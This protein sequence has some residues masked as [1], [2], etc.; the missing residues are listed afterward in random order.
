VGHSTARR[1]VTADLGEHAPRLNPYTLRFAAAADEARYRAARDPS[2][3]RFARIVLGIVLLVTIAVAFLDVWIFSRAQRPYLYV[4]HGAELVGFAI[5]FGLTYIRGWKHRHMAAM[6][7]LAVFFSTLYAVFDVLLA[8]PRTYV[9]GVLVLIV[10]IYVLLPLDFVWGVATALFCSAV[11]LAI[12]GLWHPMSGMPLAILAFL[13]VSANV[14]GAVSLYHIERLRRLDFANLLRIAAER[15]R[16][17]TLLTK[18]LPQSIADRLQRGEHDIADRFDDATVM[19]ADLVGFT[20]AAAQ[21][22]PEE[23]VAFLE[24][25]FAAFDDLVEKNGLEK[26]KTIGDAYMAAAG[27]PT[28]RADHTAAMADLAL[29]MLE[30]LPSV[31]PLDG[32]SVRVRIGLSCGPVVAGVIGDRRFAYDLW[33]DTV[34]VASRMEAYGEPMRIQVSEP[35]HRRLAGSYAFEPRGEIDVKGLGRCRT[36][37]LLGR[38]S[39]S[40]SG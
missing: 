39:G 31:A 38:G 2:D 9:A 19:F 28:R 20:R 25:I 15:A 17:R 21:H 13:V 8:A 16:Y 4:G 35:V 6:T 24:R 7:G 26:I 12:I 23:V 22:E 40:A 33:G 3:L 29:D 34:N 36:W 10:A 37:F 1:D 27:L 14:V 32:A 11:Y 30:A 18:I 5:L